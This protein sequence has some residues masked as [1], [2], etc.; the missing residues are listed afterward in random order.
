MS[1]FYIKLPHYTVNHIELYVHYTLNHIEL[2]VHYTLIKLHVNY[3]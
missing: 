3:M 2:H 1:I